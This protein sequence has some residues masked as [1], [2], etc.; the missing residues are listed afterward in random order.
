MI[1]LKV[2]LAHRAAVRIDALTAIL[3]DDPCPHGLRD[4]ANDFAFAVGAVLADGLHRP[5]IE[6]DMLTRFGATRTT[7][8]RNRVLPV[9]CNP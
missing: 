1:S 6:C 2:K 4:L 9:A 8:E 7:I 5:S 3:V